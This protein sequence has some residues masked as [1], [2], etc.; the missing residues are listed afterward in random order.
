MKLFIRKIKTLFK[1]SQKSSFEIE[2]K[3]FAYEVEDNYF[4]YRYNR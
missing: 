3:D 2:A 1:I 4:F